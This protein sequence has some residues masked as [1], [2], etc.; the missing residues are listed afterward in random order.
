[1]IGDRMD[2]DIVAEIEA[3]LQTILVLTGITS[4][5]ERAVPF[6]LHADRGPSGRP[7][8]RRPRV[9]ELT[10]RPAS[11]GTLQP[12]RAGVGD[13]PALAGPVA[14]GPG[15]GGAVGSMA[16]ST[17]QSPSARSGSSSRAVT[18][19]R[20]RP[21]PGRP[22]PRPPGR[23]AGRPAAAPGGRAGGPPQASP[24]SRSSL[25]QD[26]AAEMG[27]SRW[28]CGRSPRRPRPAR[29]GRRPGAG[30]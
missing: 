30:L 25:G 11:V 8:R 26:R 24:R 14:G 18:A 1:M 7:G 23:A 6:C 5:E 22:R 19:S 9:V 29:S 4:R 2:T 12:E 16:R 3:G 17:T 10:E 21:R 27:R 28:P 20:A 13:G 15:S